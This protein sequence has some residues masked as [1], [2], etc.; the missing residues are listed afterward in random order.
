MVNNDLIS[1]VIV[2]CNGGNYLKRCVESLLKN[3]H[4]M[5]ELIIVDNGSVDGSLEYIKS[6]ENVKLISNPVNKGAPYARN[7]GLGLAEGKYIVFL[8]NDVILTDKWLSRFIK[9]AYLDPSVGI[10]GPVSNYVSGI[11]LIPNVPY[12]NYDELQMFSMRWAHSNIDRIVYSK[13]LILFCMFVKREVVEKIGGFDPIFENWGWEDDD[14]CIRAQIAGFKLGVAYEIFVHHE[15]SKTPNVD[16]NALLVKNGKLFM[17]KWNIDEWNMNDVVK[18]PVDKIISRSFDSK[19]YVVDIPD[20]KKFKNNIYDKR[21]DGF[22]FTSFWN[23]FCG[24]IIN[25]KD[26]QCLSC[27]CRLIDA[28]INRDVESLSSFMNELN[29]IDEYK[30]YASIVK[31]VICLLRDDFD[32]AICYLYQSLQYKETLLAL[33]LILYLALFFRDYSNAKEIMNYISLKYQT[34]IK[35]CFI[36]SL[37]SNNFTQSKM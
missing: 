15:G 36:E 22:Q 5:Y 11:Q 6:I 10:W 31:A 37:L 34:V 20:Y 2:N 26:L 12:R 32:H 18:Y 19:K 24:D 29:A 8:D 3:T 17:R 25:D 16:R 9:Y 21:F 7:Q 13:R 1:I 35:S 30:A 27:H 33:K 23:I 4:C 28:M 14:Y